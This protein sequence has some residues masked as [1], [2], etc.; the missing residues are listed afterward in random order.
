LQ[1]DYNLHKVHLIINAHDR[2][3]ELFLNTLL[4]EHLREERDIYMIDSQRDANYCKR[5]AAMALCGTSIWNAHNKVKEQKIQKISREIATHFVVED[6]EI[7]KANLPYYFELCDQIRQMN[8]SILIINLPCKD[9]KITKD[10]IYMLNEI[11]KQMPV[12][13][14]IREPLARISYYHYPQINDLKI[15]EDDVIKLQ[16]IT[17]LYKSEIKPEEEW[18]TELDKK[19]AYYSQINVLRNKS[20]DLNYLDMWM[21]LDKGVLVGFEE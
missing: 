18:E 10:L 2:L 20:G 14:F 16:S 9:N 5:S 6:Q 7:I 11:T 19:G 17:S 21:D 1:L 8:T 4:V 12:T 15:T 13:I 3:W